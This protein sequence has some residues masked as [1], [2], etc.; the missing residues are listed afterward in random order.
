MRFSS[1]CSAVVGF[2]DS[3]DEFLADMREAGVTVQR[4][5]DSIPRHK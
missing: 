5:S 3:A 4:T 1:A 2:E